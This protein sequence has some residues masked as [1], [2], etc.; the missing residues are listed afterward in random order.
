M[1]QRFEDLP[2]GQITSLAFGARGDTLV[3]GNYLGKVYRLALPKS[4]ASPGQPVRARATILKQDAAGVITALAAPDAP[5]V[6]AGDDH[7]NLFLL[8]RETDRPLPIPQTLYRD[9]RQPVAALS[10]SDDGRWLYAAGTGLAAIWDLDME[11]WRKQ[12]CA[13]AGGGF[14]ARQKADFFKG[15]T[16]SPTACE[17]R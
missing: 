6:V 13:I 16:P 4:P 2:R 17:A 11:Q 14:T 3:A 15:D 1:V 10:V 9:P 8:D 7:G 5:F 12:A